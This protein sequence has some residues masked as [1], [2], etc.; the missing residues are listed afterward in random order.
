M[1]IKQRNRARQT[2]GSFLVQAPA[3]SGKTELLTQRI[4]ELLAVV[5]EPEEILALTFTRKAAAEMRHRV[6]RALSMPKPDDEASHRMQTWTLASRVA[7]RSEQLG[8]NLPEH[9][10]RLRIMT[11]DSLMHMLARQL[12]LLS[13]FG[14]MPK[15]CDHPQHFYRRAAEA[16]LEQAV[17]EYPEALECVLLHQ[18]HNT[19]AVIEMIAGLL[20]KRDQW[21]YEVAMHARDKA[22]LRAMLE[23]TLAVLLQQQLNRLQQKLPV[24]SRASLSPLLAF[25]GQ[26]KQDATLASLAAWPDAT[27]DQLPIWQKIGSQL[28]TGAGTFR[29]RITVNEGFPAGKEFAAEKQQFKEQLELLAAIPGMAEAWHDLM[30]LPV[31]PNYDDRQWQVLESLFDLLVLAVSA[32]QQQFAQAGEADFTEIALRAL[33]ALSDAH[34]APSDLLLKLDYRIHHIL[35]DEFQDTSRLQQRLLDSLTAGWSAGDG[36]TLFMVGDPM[37]SIYR[38]RKAEVGLFM[39]AAN[40]V[41][42]VPVEPLYLE[43][44]FRSAPAIVEW[45][46]RAFAAIFPDETD[47]DVVRGAVSHKVAKSALSHAGEIHLLLQEGRDDAAEAHAAVKRI[48]AELK[49]CKP[50]GTPHRIGVLA[51]TRKHLHALMPALADAGIRFRA[52][53]V[54]PLHARPEIRTLRALLRALLHPCDR[55]SWVALLRSSACGLVTPDLHA[56]I[57]GDDRPVWISM[58][59]PER[60]RL[61]SED[62]RTRAMHLAAALAPCVESAGRLP[63]RDLLES[64]MQRM[65]MAALLD[66]ISVSNVQSTL[67]L[68]ESLD[69]GGHVDFDLFDEQLEELFA[70]PDTSPEAARVELLTMHGAKGLQWDAVVLLGLGHGKKGGDAPLLAFTE[71]PIGKERALLIAPRGEKGRDDAVYRLVRS[72]ESSKDALEQARLL[73]VACTRA[74]TALYMFGCVSEEKREAGK[75]TLLS[76]LLQDGESCFGANVEWIAAEDAISVP[77]RKALTRI[78][79]MPA[80]PEPQRQQSEMALEFVWAGPDAA[81]VGTAVHAA[82]QQVAEKGVENWEKSDTSKAMIRMRRILMREGLSGMLLESALN[83]AAKAL[84]KALGS[85][86]ARWVLS[87]EHADAHC[88]WALSAIEAGGVYHSVIDRSFVDQEG[89]RWIIDYKT[90]SHQGSGLDAFLASETERYTPQLSRYRA[91]LERLE[92]DRR[93]RTAL[94][95]PVMDILH[96]VETGATDAA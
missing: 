62:G 61:L 78:A 65:G 81:P 53:K 6:I 95:F 79:L 31:A 7:S 71:A 88:E 82:L 26:Q 94:Y 86:Q 66:E 32:L 93:V 14:E 57:A 91:L 96:E 47:E 38:F 90:G 25:A 73:Y 12:P 27:L 75:G 54:L 85:E 63:V 17:K 45:V 35:I 84:Q 52:I 59:D 48:Q 9:P 51:R 89:S 1:S 39:Q 49:Q 2:N 72:I 68:I 58:N 46:N 13:G 76:L 36:R 28:L 83:R 40:G 37:Q 18:D 30:K 67:M 20:A 74:E 23:Q 3:G 70:A 34:G 24:E 5:D 87:G 16:T 64:A 80:I 42:P 77:A 21:L 60:L 11:I 4:L 33:D 55:E 22:G 92:P 29:S 44:N 50:D 8:W 10:G 56:L 15:P 69:Q 43:Q 41:L 19:S